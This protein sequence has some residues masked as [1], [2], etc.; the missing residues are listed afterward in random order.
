MFY[1]LKSSLRC[2]YR[3][4]ISV[5]SKRKQCKKEEGT[6]IENW[7]NYDCVTMCCTQTH[8]IPKNQYDKPHGFNDCRRWKTMSHRERCIVNCVWHWRFFEYPYCLHSE[9]GIC[10]L[11]DVRPEWQCIECC[12]TSK[13]DDP[14]VS[15]QNF[16]WSCWYFV[17]WDFTNMC[18]SHLPAISTHHRLDSASTASVYSAP[19]KLFQSIHA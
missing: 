8:N 9:H 15:I 3:K 5:S 7:N 6:K 2:S 16:S 14:T 1:I 10:A 17:T 19:F 18:S 12:R 11:C 13:L 4:Y